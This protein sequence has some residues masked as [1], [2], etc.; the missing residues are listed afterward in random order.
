MFNFFLGGLWLLVKD[1]YAALESVIAP[2]RPAWKL[3]APVGLGLVAGWMV[4][5]PVHELM[6]VAGC[7]IA[8]GSVTELR[9][10]PIYG[11]AF[12]RGLFPFIVAS[13][14]YA[15]RLSGFSTNGSDLVYLATDA[16]PYL[17]TVLVGVPLLRSGW[18][19][20][21]DSGQWKSSR[22]WLLGPTFILAAA[23][24]ISLTGDYFEMATVILTR[25]YAMAGL[26]GLEVLRSDD[27]FRLVGDL[28]EGEISIGEG[29]FRMWIVS[30]AVILCSLGLSLSL[31]SWTYHLGVAWETI[32]R[33]RGRRAS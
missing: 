29:G 23:P 19:W 13:G 31:A 8:G 5:V 30:G 15:G 3:L 27:V 18:L 26:A 24:I 22:L 7:V 17:L 14:E 4:Y 25:G 11:A 9:L 2:E 32:L 28:H 10:A 6:H 16:A 33:R 20:P 21:S 12:L 1:L